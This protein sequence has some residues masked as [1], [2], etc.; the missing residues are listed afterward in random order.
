MKTKFNFYYDGTPIQKSEFVKQVPSNW[1]NELNEW[2]EYTWG[3]YRA[4]KLD[5]E[6]MNIEDKIEFI[7]NHI[8]N[9]HCQKDFED[10]LTFSK[11]EINQIYKEIWYDSL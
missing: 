2:D 11:D 6:H 1:M 8:K 4:S 3:Y 7:K 5:G 9:T 10:L